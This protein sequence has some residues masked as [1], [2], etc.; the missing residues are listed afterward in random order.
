MHTSTLGPAE[1]AQTKARRAKRAHALYSKLLDTG[2]IAIVFAGDEEQDRECLAMLFSHL[3][4]WFRAGLRQLQHRNVQPQETP[5]FNVL[6]S[7]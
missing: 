6:G 2:N 1:Q 5:L 4:F 3:G 7:R